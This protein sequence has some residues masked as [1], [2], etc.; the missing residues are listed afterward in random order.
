MIGAM[1][2]SLVTS[3]VMALAA[4]SASAAVSIDWVTIGDPGNAAQSAANRTHAFGDGGDGF[5]AVADTYRIARNETTILDYTEF[6]NAVAAT[7]TYS[8]YNTSMGTDGNIAG[9]NRGGSSGSYT[10]SVTG[11]G[12]RPITYV[13]WFDA[14]RYTNWL[15][16]GQGIGSTETGAYTLVNGQTSG[17]AP[18][19]NV[20]A[21]IYLPTEN[22]WFKAA[23]YDPNKGT[24][25][26]YWLHGNQSDSMTT[27][28]V[29]A[30]GAAN[31]NDGD[32]AVTQ[33]GS[34]SGSQNYLTD[35]GAYG[36]DSQS[37][38][39]LD[40]V[41]GNV[42][43]WNDLDAESGSVRG[44]R[45]GSWDLV[46]FGLR[47]SIRVDNDPSSENSNV[48]FRVASVPEPSSILL[49][50]MFTA[51]IAARRKR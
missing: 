30:T 5:G 14:A 17:T 48:G 46:E 38:Y 47:S 51:A 26:G 24:S 1:K 6:L 23:Y 34:Y 12:A 21:T 33:S 41:A 27:N 4:A 13:S 45:G 9:I 10:Y 36:T 11:S 39:G 37:F 32:Y 29:G 19:R 20:G 18:G 22:E 2:H 44:L 31:Y 49:T 25:G 43:E 16:N 35:A 3:L 15:H 7:D 8:L 42:F 28:T 50:M 40:D